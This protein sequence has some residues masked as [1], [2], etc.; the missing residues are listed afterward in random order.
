MRLPAQ[1]FGAAAC[2]ALSGMHEI[3]GENAV[4]AIRAEESLMKVRFF[5]WDYN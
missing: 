5:I 3:N 2:L 4:P 1:F